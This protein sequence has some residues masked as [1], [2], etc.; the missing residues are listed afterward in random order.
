[1]IVKC[2]YN[3]NVGLTI[4]DLRE[5]WRCCPASECQDVDHPSFSDPAKL[6]LGPGLAR[7]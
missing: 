7:V 2:R 1:M 5:H 4:I 6:M 3:A